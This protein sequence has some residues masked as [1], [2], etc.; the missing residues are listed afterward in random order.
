MKQSKKQRQK[1][2][3]QKIK[4]RKKAGFQSVLRMF[5]GSNLLSNN[6]KY[7]RVSSKMPILRFLKSQNR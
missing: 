3:L 6:S 5:Y 2:S 4:N 7:T 1:R